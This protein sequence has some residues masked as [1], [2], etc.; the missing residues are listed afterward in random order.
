MNHTAIRP[1]FGYSRLLNITC[2]IFAKTGR[3]TCVLIMRYTKVSYWSQTKTWQARSSR[4]VLRSKIFCLWRC[5]RLNHSQY[6]R[7]KKAGQK[8]SATILSYKT[9]K[10]HYFSE[11]NWRT[12]LLGKNYTRKTA[13]FCMILERTGISKKDFEIWNTEAGSWCDI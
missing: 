9:F 10:K 6:K 1:R 12:R 3:L 13:S 2:P 11:E 7:H 4:S 5:S 8:K